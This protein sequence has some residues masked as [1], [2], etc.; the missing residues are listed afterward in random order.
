M[1]GEYQAGFT[2]GK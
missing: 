1:T 2:A